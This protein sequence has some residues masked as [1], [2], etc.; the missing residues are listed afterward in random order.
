MTAQIF[1]AAFHPQKLVPESGHFRPV[2][3]HPQ[4]LKPNDVVVAG[5]RLKNPNDPQD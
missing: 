1:A 2:S 5:K 3:G 4:I